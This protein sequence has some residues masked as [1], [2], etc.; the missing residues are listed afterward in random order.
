MTHFRLVA[1]LLAGA[2][3]LT[4][5]ASATDAYGWPSPASRYSPLVG[6][7]GAGGSRPLVPEGGP[8]GPGCCGVRP[9][10]ATGTMYRP[11][12]AAPGRWQLTPERGPFGIED[13]F[14]G[15]RGPAAEDVPSTMRP[16]S[17][18]AYEFSPPADLAG[19]ARAAPAGGVCPV[20]GAKLGSM[21]PPVRVSV[22]GRTVWLCC[23]GCEAKLRQNPRLYLGPEASAPRIAPQS[24]D[25]RPSPARDVPVDSRAESGRVR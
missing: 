21:G 25:A 10:P 1:A 7:C 13:S 17:L 2:A 15:G 23:A 3:G 4:S 12:P 5:T 6:C 14:G 22:G 24:G 11:L 18:A 16:R 8:Y 20:T 9:V 19:P